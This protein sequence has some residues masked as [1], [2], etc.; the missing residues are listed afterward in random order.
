MLLSY[1]MKSIYKQ[2]H[3]YLEFPIIQITYVIFWIPLGCIL[4]FSIAY[5]FIKILSFFMV[6]LLY[7]IF[8][9]AIDLFILSGRLQVLEAV[10]LFIIG[11]VFDILLLVLG[12][13]YIKIK[14]DNVKVEG[15]NEK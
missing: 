5:L 7:L 10:Y 13:G 12:L 4:S 11:I 14:L 8:P 3:F 6:S 1:I 2:E 9:L 15:E